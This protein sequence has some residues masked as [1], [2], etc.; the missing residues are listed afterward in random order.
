M[1]GRSALT[2]NKEGTVR[3]GVA[4]VPLTTALSESP[5]I[6]STVGESKYPAA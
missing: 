4:A 1:G 5:T 2:V 3:P 6:V